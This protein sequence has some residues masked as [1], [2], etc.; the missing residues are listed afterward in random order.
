VVGVFSVVLGVVSCFFISSASAMK[1]AAAAM[2]EVA[3]MMSQAC[4]AGIVVSRYRSE[5]M[6]MKSEAGPANDIPS[7]IRTEPVMLIIKSF[8]RRCFSAASCLLAYSLSA[9]FNS[10]KNKVITSLSD[11]QTKTSP[12]Q[13]A[14]PALGI[15][16][17]V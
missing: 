15:C 13:P 9:A 3:P 10:S 12:Q 8:L 6:S 5:P 1:S 16:R 7:A 17:L 2:A 11:I 14:N 4:H